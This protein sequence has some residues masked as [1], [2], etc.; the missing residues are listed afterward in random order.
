MIFHKCVNSHTCQVPTAEIYFRFFIFCIIE[1]F[2]GNFW[3]IQVISGTLD[4]NYE[5]L[6]ICGN[7]A[8]VN[9]SLG[10]LLDG[11]DFNFTIGA[12]VNTVSIIVN[13][14]NKFTFNK[15]FY[16][17]RSTMKLGIVDVIVCETP[18]KFFWDL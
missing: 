7:I 17:C 13:M 10:L 2:G 15:I 3:V 1:V 14:L 9:K 6:V 4:I 11:F 12:K 8:E 16:C 5:H 18:S